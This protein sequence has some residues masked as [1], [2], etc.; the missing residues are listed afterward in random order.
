MSFNHINT[1][2]KKLNFNGEIVK[3]WY[4]NGVLVFNSGYKI[5]YKVDSS[6]SYEEEV[7]SDASILSPT[8][9]TPTKSGYTFVGWKEDTT[10]NSSVLTSK[11]A[12]E[13]STLYAVF[14]KDVTLTYYDNSTTAKT[15][16]GS[17]YYNNS[18]VTNPS[19]TM[20]QAS[21]SGWTARGWSTTCQGDATINYS[22][23]ATITLTGNLTIYGLYQ[24]TITVTYY[25]NSTTAST[26]TGTRYCASG[27]GYV[28]PS[29]TLA[30][31]AKSSWTKRGWSTGTSGNS[32]I[33]YND[34]T[35]FTRE[36]DVT[37]YGMYQ[38]TITVTYYNNS[39]SASTTTGTRY[40]NS[41]K[42]VYTN[43]SFTLAQASK[44]GWTARGWSTTNSGSATVTYSNNTA[45][46][47]ESNVT[48]YG[49]YQ[50][51]ITAS[52]NANGGSGSTSASTGTAYWAP[53][54]T[55]GATISLR[56]NGFT[57]SGY[58][59]Q[60]WAQGSTSGTQYAAGASVTLT[61]NT[62][63]YAVWKMASQ[64]FTIKMKNHD[65]WSNGWEDLEV[66]SIDSNNYFSLDSNGI[67]MTCKQSCRL[68]LSY[69]YDNGGGDGRLWLSYSTGGSTELDFREGD[70][71]SGS[72][73]V[74]VSAGTKIYFRTMSHYATGDGQ[75]IMR[76]TNLT[77]TCTATA[78]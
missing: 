68:N 22:N 9:F 74:T 62:T 24:K 14:K 7:D 11:V 13:D 2:I 33:T 15:K 47:R 3:K 23:G 37:L 10:A 17:I 75:I 52:Y 58:S 12:T 45:F 76:T 41:G 20:T 69:T 35:A 70:N 34:N 29:F 63:F 31:S 73:S 60:K 43:P 6:T 46:T 32:S 16:T 27:G 71:L 65:N 59:F 21:A 44:S 39:S 56:S 67:Y 72:G 26:T 36:S 48:L 8:S 5:T 78:T 66:K 1:A 55:I 61:A 54:G 49:L 51:T 40:Y 30:Q 18:N 77:F 25:N 50:Q 38:Q 42:N 4:H 28:N 57:R 64:T 53:A 19:F